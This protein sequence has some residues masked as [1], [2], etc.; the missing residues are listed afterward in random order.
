M[1]RFILIAA[2]LALFISCAA[3]QPV[4]PRTVVLTVDGNV[5]EVVDGT[6]DHPCEGNWNFCDQVMATEKLIIPGEDDEYGS[7]IYPEF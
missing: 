4:E 6:K 1:K 3:Q 5:V 7:Y 2:C